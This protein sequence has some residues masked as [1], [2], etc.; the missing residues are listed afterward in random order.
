MGLDLSETELE[1]LRLR[2][3][4]H[5]VREIAELRGTAIGTVKNQF[6]RIYRKLGVPNA[7]AAVA[8]AVREGLIQ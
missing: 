2:S 3:Q 4:G 7:T 5:R 1:V 8:K 6:D